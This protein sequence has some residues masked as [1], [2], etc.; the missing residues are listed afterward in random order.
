M[1]LF[2]IEVTRTTSVV[3]RIKARVSE[4]K[5]LSCGQRPMKKR[6]MCSQCASVFEYQI[7]KL[8][9]ERD[10]RKYEAELIKT[11]QLLAAQEIRFLRASLKNPLVAIAGKVATA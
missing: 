11:G 4:D 7:A 3:K 1:E 10:K 6:G 8:K 9:S 2:V 5:C